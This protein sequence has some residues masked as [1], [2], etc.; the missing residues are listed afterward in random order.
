[1]QVNAGPCV[2]GS[3]LFGPD[4]ITATDSSS[5]AREYDAMADPVGEDVEMTD[6]AVGSR[7]SV[8]ELLQPKREP[9]ASAASKGKFV[10]KV[11]ARPGQARVRTQPSAS[12]QTETKEE[13]PVNVDPTIPLA[14]GDIAGRSA[15]M[16]TKAANAGGSIP[17]LTN[18]VK[19]EPMVDG[20]LHKVK[21]E[22][23]DDA[24]GKMQLDAVL[25]EEPAKV[26]LKEEPSFKE[27][28]AVVNDEPMM[29]EPVDSMPGVDRVV[30]EIDVFLTSQVDPETNVRCGPS[31]CQPLLKICV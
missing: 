1:M 7:P 29:K 6:T 4:V 28:V 14:L 12:L 2:N 19:P 30:R 27:E 3:F 20:P 9:A 13:I 18:V 17:L 31:L 10:P 15:S 25:S 8:F 26:E 24:D 5:L 21:A 22:P 16:D 11:K 23:Q